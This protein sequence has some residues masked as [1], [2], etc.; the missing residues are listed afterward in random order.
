MGRR[1]P[2]GAA[3]ELW[4][5]GICV[6]AGYWQRPDLTEIAFHDIDGRRWYRTGDRVCRDDAGKLRFLGR[7]D[8]QLKIR[9]NRIDLTK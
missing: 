7:Q 9:G 2:H 8:D 3:G 1:L 5:G 6:G 4:L